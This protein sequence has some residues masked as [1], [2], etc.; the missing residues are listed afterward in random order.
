MI[1]A[2]HTEDGRPMQTGFKHHARD[3][4]RDMRRH[5]PAESPFKASQLVSHATPRVQPPS[6]PPCH[7]LNH[8]SMCAGHAACLA[9]AR[10]TQTLAC[11]PHTHPR[12]QHLPCGGAALLLPA[13]HPLAAGL[14]F[15]PREAQEQQ[16]RAQEQAHQQHQQARKQA[17][18]AL[19]RRNEHITA[20]VDKELASE[21]LETKV[22]RHRQVLW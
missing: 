20:I 11:T 8:A 22:K 19:K 5:A 6:L 12:Q 16:A 9:C 15:G 2:K 1:T 21:T 13:R 3:V 10:L 14:G 7:P 4:C 17:A 18:A